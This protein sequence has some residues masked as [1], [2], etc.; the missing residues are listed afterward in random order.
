MERG[1]FQ[2][3][4]KFVAD[5]KQAVSGLQER[6]VSVSSIGNEVFEQFYNQGAWL[7]DLYLEDGEIF[8]VASEG[9]KLFRASV[10]IDENGDITLGEMQEVIA[11][12]DARMAKLI[13]EVYLMP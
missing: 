8:A 2:S 11:K 6:A 3:I 7:N 12:F 4:N 10:D 5:L 9:G 13:L 1:F